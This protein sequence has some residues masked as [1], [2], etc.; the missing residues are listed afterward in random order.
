MNAPGWILTLWGGALA[1][2]LD[3]KKII[4][5]FQGIQFLSIILLLVLLVLGHLRP[6]MIILISLTVGVTDSLSMPSFQTIVPS[7]VKKEEITHAITLNSIQFNLSRTL[8]PAVAGLVMAQFG[9]A[10]CFGANALSYVPFFL[11]IFWI[12]PTRGFEKSEIKSSSADFEKNL[13]LR[14]LF[15]QREIRILLMTVFVTT[16]FCSPLITFCPVLVKDI[17]SGQIKDFGNGSSA[18]G[19]GGLAGA[20]LAFFFA[21]KIKVKTPGQFGWLLGV[22]VAGVALCRSLTLF[23]VLMLLGGF[24]LTVANTASNSNLQSRATNHVR[25]RYASLYQLSF[26]GGIALGALLTGFVASRFGIV[27]A[28]FLNGALAVIFHSV[29]LLV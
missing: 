21:R 13:S 25:G 22:V 28:F 19:M 2:R 24:L 10:A 11:S 8:G 1:D 14:D 5:F 27:T 6:W 12:Y 18:F 29:L 26:R 15:R 7:L 20:L 16:L 9:A 23:M 3:R 4:L 17:F